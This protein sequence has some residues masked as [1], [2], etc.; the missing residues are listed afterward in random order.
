MAEDPDFAS[1]YIHLAYA[2]SNQNKPKAEVLLP[3]ERAFRMSD[4]TSDRER[5]FIRGSYYGFLGDDAKAITAYETLLTLYPDHY[6]GLN[7][8]AGLYLE[9]GR[10]R[11]AAELSA[12]A[13]DMRPKDYHSNV[14]A[15]S[16]LAPLDRDRFQSYVRRALDLVTP[17]ALERN[18]GGVSWLEL[19]Q[20]EEYWLAG[21]IPE[22]LRA[23]DAVAAK[24]DSLP[25]KAREAYGDDLFGVYLQLG[26]LDSA[27]GCLQKI[28]DPLFRHE[29]MSRVSFMRRIRPR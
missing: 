27:A 15:A 10:D 7:N 5:Y 4:T 25:E 20:A 11:D 22:A 3:A 17:A 1:A 2:L 18:P 28:S 6:W 19:V 8:L 24:I 13:A 29:K 12:R 23:T 16:C 9:S 21:E 26:R 14:A